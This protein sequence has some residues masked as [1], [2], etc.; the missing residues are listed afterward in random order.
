MTTIQFPAALDKNILQELYA[1]DVDYA[2][3]MFDLF[4]TEIIPQVNGLK[5]VA[6]QQNWPD[7]RQICHKIKPTFSMVGVTQLEHLFEKLEDSQNLEDATAIID[8]IHNKLA[9]V[10]PAVQVA[11]THLKSLQDEN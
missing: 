11:H 3:M 5:Q 9:Q 8:I 6:E 4:L 2:T 10:L 1:D 7:F